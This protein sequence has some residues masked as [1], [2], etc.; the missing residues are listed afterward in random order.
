MKLNVFAKKG[1]SKDGH[2]FPIF[3]TTLYKKDGSELKASIKFR[4][5]APQLDAKKCPCV[6]D[7]A[8]TDANLVIS[9]IKDPETGDFLYDLSTGIVKE[10]RTLW[11]S[12]FTYVGPYIDHS[13]DDFDD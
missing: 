11:V 4:Q 7:V 2:E 1:K 8:K 10:S 13:L 12:N 9:Q 3:L 6:I 5:D